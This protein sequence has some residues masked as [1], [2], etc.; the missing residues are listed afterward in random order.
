MVKNVIHEQ[1]QS[2]FYYIIYIYIFF[3]FGVFMKYTKNIIS[4][5]KFMTATR[6]IR[7]SEQ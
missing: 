4:D 1:E 3:W 7:K 2:L 5:H 6:V